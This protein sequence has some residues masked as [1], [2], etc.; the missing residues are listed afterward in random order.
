M[1][2]EL[3]SEQAIPL[4]TTAHLQLLDLEPNMKSMVSVACD[5]HNFPDMQPE[6]QQMTVI[7]SI[8]WSHLSLADLLNPA[9]GSKIED[10]LAIDQLSDDG[11]RAILEQ[12]HAF[13]HETSNTMRVDAHSFLDLVDIDSIY[14][15]GTE[16]CSSQA[17]SQM[18]IDHE[19]LTVESGISSAQVHGP[20]E[21]SPNII[22]IILLF[23][24]KF[25]LQ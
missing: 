20:L 12:D 8:V 22:G 1:K 18:S 15:E 13:E 4:D 14:R 16:D 9:Y 25:D 21:D 3:I 17:D 10:Q 5:D 11:A 6:M 2:V 19:A 24:N 23:I 7:E